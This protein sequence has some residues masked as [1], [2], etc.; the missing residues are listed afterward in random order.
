MISQMRK[1]IER[2]LPHITV[3]ISY[4][5]TEVHCGTIYKA[6]GWSAVATNEGMSWSNETRKRNKEQSLAAKV[7]W[8]FR[9]KP[10]CTKSDVVSADVPD[11]SGL[12]SGHK[13]EGSLAEFNRY[14]AGDR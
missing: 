3:L 14:I 9:M 4:Q 12:W 7:R 8:E 13:L 2:E 6:S 5:D 1:Y 11:C 10:A